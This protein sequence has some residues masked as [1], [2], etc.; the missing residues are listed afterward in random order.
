[1]INENLCICIQEGD[2]DLLP[3][4]WGKV[5]HLCFMLCGRYYTRYSDKFAAC[6]VELSD[7]RQECYIAFLK[8]VDAFKPDGKSLFTSYL[9]YPIKN[10]AAELLGI[11]NIE[12]VNR[13]PLD[14]AESLEKP[15]ESSENDAL[16]LGD[17]LSDEQALQ[18]YENILDRIE[19]KETRAVLSRALGQLSE[20][21]RQVITMYYFDD[22]SLN[23]IGVQLGV[24]GERA[25]QIRQK[26]LKCLRYMPEVVMLRK[27]QHIERSLHHFTNTSSP[28]YIRAQRKVSEIIARGEYLSYGQKQAIIYECMVRSEFT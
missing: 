15:F 17:T 13:K 26:A 8:A 1:M 23:D 28:D 2:T 11:R 20:V 27:G 14:N 21:Q 7:L 16:T 24:S 3:V 19:D 4:L 22:M 5:R 18:P 9:N 10:S 12:R 6:G 25:R